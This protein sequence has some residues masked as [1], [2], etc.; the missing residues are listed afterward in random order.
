MIA[1]FTYR[2]LPISCSS[3]AADGKECNVITE[4]IDIT[5]PYMWDSEDDFDTPY[6]PFECDHEDDC[7]SCT[8][9]HPEHD[10]EPKEKERPVIEIPDL[11]RL[12]PTH[13][14]A[15]LDDYFERNPW[16]F[17]ASRQWGNDHET[18]KSWHDLFSLYTGAPF[19]QLGYYEDDDGERSTGWVD[20]EIKE[21]W[22]RELFGYFP[23]VIKEVE[24]VG[25]KLEVD[26]DEDEAQV[27]AQLQEGSQARGDTAL[28]G[29]ATTWSIVVPAYISSAP[30]PLD[31]TSQ[32]RLDLPYDC[33]PDSPSPSPE[34]KS[35]F[36]NLPGS[37]GRPSGKGAGKKTA[38]VKKQTQGKAG[39]SG[40]YAGGGGVKGGNAQAPASGKGKKDKGKGS[41]GGGG[42]GKKGKGRQSD[43]AWP[44]RETK[45]SMCHRGQG[46]IQMFIMS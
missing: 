37:R 21:R 13:T 31:Q 2:E 1:Y 16:G 4:N 5:D 35:R 32:P 26:S 20:R 22:V 14:L 29:L 8:S 3:C 27:D 34:P 24:D 30:F 41:R 10:T 36:P 12:A 25:S 11:L 7:E 38:A 18:G 39:G 19:S 17:P 6:S 45:P 28:N 40:G 9:S 33:P 46:K 15:E 44:K 42:G 43:N 23:G